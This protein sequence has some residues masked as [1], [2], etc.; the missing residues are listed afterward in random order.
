[1]DKVLDFVSD[2]LEGIV[3]KSRSDGKGVIP[4]SNKKSRIR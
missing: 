1:V 4:F 3:E 2:N